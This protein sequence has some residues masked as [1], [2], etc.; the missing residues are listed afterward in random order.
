VLMS[1]ITA[2]SSPIRQLPNPS[3]MSQLISKV[4][5]MTRLQIRS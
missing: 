5:D 3:P 1:G 4:P 2:L